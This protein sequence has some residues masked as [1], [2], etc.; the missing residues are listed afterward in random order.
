[1]GKMKTVWLLIL[2]TV[3]VLTVC[4]SIIRLTYSAVELSE[5]AGESLRKRASSMEDIARGGDGETGGVFGEDGFRDILEMM[6]E[7][8]RPED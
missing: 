3:F 7:L 2:L 1:M 6:E 8:Y 5:S 4:F